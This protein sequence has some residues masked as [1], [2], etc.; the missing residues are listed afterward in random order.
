MGRKSGA[1]RSEGV[2]SEGSDCESNS[3]DEIIIESVLCV[4]KDREE[5]QH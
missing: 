2:P 4:K 5:V 3:L 1:E